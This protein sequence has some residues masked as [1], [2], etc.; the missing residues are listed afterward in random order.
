MINRKLTALLLALSVIGCLLL[1]IAIPLI[2]SPYVMSSTLGLIMMAEL[3]SV[4]VAMQIIVE[5]KGDQIAD[6]YL[7]WRGKKSKV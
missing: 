1:L 5:H 4:L 2:T 6:K 3:I 7:A